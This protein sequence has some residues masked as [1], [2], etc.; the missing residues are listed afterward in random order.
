MTQAQKMLFLRYCPHIYKDKAD[1]FP[2]R[3]IGC[4]VFSTPQRSASFPKWF[5]DPQ[6]EG[7]AMILEYAIYYDYDIQHLYDLEH[8]WV[9]VD[10]DGKVVNCWCSFHGM[11]LRAAGVSAF[12]MDGEHPVLYAQP[13]KH[14]MLPHPELFLLHPDLERACGEAAGGGV[15]VPG[16]LS[17]RVKT[18]PETDEKVTRYIRQHYS[19]APTMDFVPERIDQ[20][21]LL[22]WGELLDKIPEL[23]E[24]QLRMIGG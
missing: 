15:L 13:G 14:A 4:T 16:F 22:R 24:G 1:P 18:D 21:Q 5:V 19:F 9:A 11:R 8:I 20:E 10:G 3:Y 6:A 17:D 12:A 2:V 7:A 23:I